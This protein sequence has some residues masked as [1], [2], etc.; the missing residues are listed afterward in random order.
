M[1]DYSLAIEAYRWHPGKIEN[2]RDLESNMDLNCS[3]L[4]TDRVILKGSV[5]LFVK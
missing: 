2:F 1:F 5:S 3:F 4:L